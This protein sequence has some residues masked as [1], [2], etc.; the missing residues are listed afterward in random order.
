MATT[1]PSDWVDITFTDPY[2]GSIWQDAG[3]TVANDVIYVATT[4]VLLSSTPDFIECIPASADITVTPPS[5]VGISGKKMTFKNLS[6]SYKVTLDLSG[7][8]ADGITSIVLTEQYE[9]ITL[10]SNDSQWLIWG[11]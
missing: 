2:L 9:V 11:N 4:S 10:I 5:P 8:T 6:A 3:G 7:Y 1:S